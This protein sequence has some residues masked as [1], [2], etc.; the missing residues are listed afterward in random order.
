MC[1]L[2]VCACEAPRPLCG[3]SGVSTPVAHPDAHPTR[4][5]VRFAGMFESDSDTN[6]GRREQH[7]TERGV[8]R[9]GMTAFSNATTTATTSAPPTGQPSRRRRLL[10]PCGVIR[11][12]PAGCS[13]VRASRTL[14][15]YVDAV[16]LGI[17]IS[18]SSCRRR[19]V[20][21]GAVPVVAMEPLLA[22]DFSR[23]AFF[24]AFFCACS[25]FCSAT[26]TFESAYDCVTGCADDA[27]AGR[28]GHEA[29]ESCSS[30]DES[31]RLDARISRTA[32]GTARHRSNRTYRANRFAWLSEAARLSHVEW[33]RLDSNQGPTDYESAALTS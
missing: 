6:R 30:K 14:R 5:I 3:S 32:R 4:R 26:L 27:N 10:E 13:D 15:P 25:A 22:P 16:A 9:A 8:R 7:G 2:R 33:A 31:G 18:F 24:C 1:R 12:Q 23:S 29:R 28:S 19:T 11:G 17:L 20:G 21:G